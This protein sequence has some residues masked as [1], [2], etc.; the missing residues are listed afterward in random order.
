LPID[1]PQQREKLLLCALNKS[2]KNTSTACCWQSEATSR[3]FWLPISIFVDRARSVS[4]SEEEAYT[5]KP[6]KK[7]HHTVA[8]I[9]AQQHHQAASSERQSEQTDGNRF[10]Q[11]RLLPAR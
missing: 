10:E 7:R 11:L 9:S 3:L 5:R 1:L 4:A 2:H 6:G 8:R